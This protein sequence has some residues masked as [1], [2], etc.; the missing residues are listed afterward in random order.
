M[1]MGMEAICA[2]WME[3]RQGLAGTIGM[4]S[5]FTK[6]GE[7]GNKSSS[8]LAQLYQLSFWPDIISVTIPWHTQNH[9]TKLCT[10]GVRAHVNN[11]V[12][13]PIS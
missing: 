13:E 6:M 2:W 3:M 7:N 4:D 10:V 12:V 1:A 9:N 5:M 8:F 11:T